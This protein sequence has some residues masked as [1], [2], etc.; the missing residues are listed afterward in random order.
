ADGPGGAATFDGLR[1]SLMPV[2]PLTLIAA[3]PLVRHVRASV[4]DALAAPYMLAAAARGIPYR[5]RLWR[6]AL[7]AAANP[8]V[9]LFGLSF[10]ALFSASMMVEGVMSWPGLGPLLRDPVRNRDGQVIV[11]GVILGTELFPAGT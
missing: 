9:S 5:R 6:S 8:L 1:H 2:L 4:L 10:A 3:P 7:R 11:A